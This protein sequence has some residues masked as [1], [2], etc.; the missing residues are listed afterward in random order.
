LWEVND[1]NVGDSVWDLGASLFLSGENRPLVGALR[2]WCRS[3]FTHRSDPSRLTPQDGMG[4]VV[5]FERLLREWKNLFG[6]LLGLPSSANLFFLVPC[7]LSTAHLL[8]G[9]TWAPRLVEAFGKFALDYRPR[10]PATSAKAASYLDRFGWLDDSPARLAARARANGDATRLAALGREPEH[11][12]RERLR[13]LAADAQ[14]MRPFLVRNFRPEKTIVEL[15]GGGV[16]AWAWDLPM[17]RIGGVVFAPTAR[18][19]RLALS[20]GRAS[21]RMVGVGFQGGPSCTARAPNRRAR[22]RHW[23]ARALAWP[24][25]STSSICSTSGCSTSTTGLTSNACAARRPPPRK[26]SW[27]MTRWR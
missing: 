5:M 6:G 2:A 25:T 19:A 13:R 14:E 26:G 22:P 8:F 24:R 9:R 16:V 10:D 17:A 18:D 23:L 4:P 1:Q 27:A 15:P 7:H 3:Y 21:A 11:A 12:L 20:G